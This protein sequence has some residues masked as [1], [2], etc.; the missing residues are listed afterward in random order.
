MG[1]SRK[2]LSRLKRTERGI[3]VNGERRWMSDRLRPGDRVQVR[4][5][6]ERSDDILPQ[7]IPLDI[8]YEDD[9]LLV[10][11]KPAGLI[12][13]PTVG[14]YIN[15]LANAVV[16]Y[17]Q[18]KGRAYRFRPVHRL[19]RDTS[20]V[21]AIAKNAYVHQRLS[22][23]LQTGRVRKTYV[24]Y[25]H[26]HPSS[27]A[28]TIDAPIDRDPERPHIR[29]VTAS[30]YPSVTHYETEREYGAAARVRLRPESGRTHQIRVH[31]KHIGHP[32][33]GDEM[34]GPDSPTETERRL[35]ALAGRQALH[36]AALGF[37]HP[38]TG[39][40]VWFEAPLPDDLLRLEQAL[41]EMSGF[42]SPPKMTDF[43]RFGLEQ[44]P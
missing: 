42:S 21:L 35:D 11:N 34:Y 6:A 9:H 3:T 22:E 16:H 23:Q 43:P 28:G 31:M 29:I 18:Q 8:L 39:R 1:V 14:H 30:G 17:W 36:A 2:L 24:A 10:V 25:V 33:I 7:P 32:L 12:V 19:D 41:A 38:V 44:P 15:T 37:D 26:G 5:P 4:M 13:H 40:P 20:G 27:P